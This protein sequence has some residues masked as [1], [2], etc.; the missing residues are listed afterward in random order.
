MA[1]YEKA[2]EISRQIP[3]QS[4]EYVPKAMPPILGTW[5]LTATYIIALFLINNSVLTATGGVVGLVYL[6]LGAIT[7]LIPCVI[8]VAQLGMMFP[9]EGSL[10]NWTYKALGRY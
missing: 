7:F 4:E 8:A 1:T 3:L 5:D 10:Y 6:L 2:S 9:Y